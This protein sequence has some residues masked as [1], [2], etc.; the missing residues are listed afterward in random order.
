MD[1]FLTFL[2]GAPLWLLALLALAENTAILLGTVG[3]GG[4]LAR[5]FGDRPVVGSDAVPPVDATQ[6]MLA[7]STVFL[8]SLVTFLG[9]LLWR[10]GSIRIR[11][12]AGVAATLLDFL[13]LVFVMDVCMYVLHRVAHFPPFFR[14]IHRTHHNYDSP[15]PLTLFVLNPL[16]ALSFGLLWLALLCCYDATWLGMSLY[17]AFNVLFG[18]VGHVGVE[19]LPDSWKRL[20]LLRYVSTSSFHAGHHRDEGYNFG[21]YTLIW[22]RMF[23]ALPRTLCE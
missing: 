15:R 11:V 18:L 17:L 12:D 4:W 5:R 14:M 9:L 23:G 13:L 19:P 22:D 7:A 10:S 1:T 3:I 21:F 16:E 20:P 6:V 8:N 2:R